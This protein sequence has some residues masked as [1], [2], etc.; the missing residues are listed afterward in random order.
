[1]P[2]IAHYAPLLAKFVC[3]SSNLPSN[4]NTWC[5]FQ[6]SRYRAR[7]MNKVKLR[8]RNTAQMIIS[9]YRATHAKGGILFNF[10][11]FF[12]YSISFSSN[13]YPNTICYHYGKIIFYDF[14]HIFSCTLSYVAPVFPF[15]ISIR[16]VFHCSFVSLFSLWLFKANWI[17]MTR[18]FACIQYLNHHNT[19]KSLYNN[20][21]IE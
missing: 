18:K 13:Y 16:L 19:Y 9:K 15:M 1:M 17:N 11:I 6:L 21:R 20:D 7:P 12:L 8:L 10:W 5:N 2:C 3:F 4:A 14:N